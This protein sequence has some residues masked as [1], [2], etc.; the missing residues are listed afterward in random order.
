MAFGHEQRCPKTACGRLMSYEKCAGMVSLV[1]HC[2]YRQLVKDE[3]GGKAVDAETAKKK[4][5][6]LIREGRGEEAIDV[7]EISGVC[8]D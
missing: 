8:G 6:R 7:L 3:W 5:I 4:I 1:C 2:G